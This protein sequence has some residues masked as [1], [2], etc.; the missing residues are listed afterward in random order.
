M[1]IGFDAKRLFCNFTGLGN[2]S[3]T[4]VKNLAVA[5]PH[6]SYHLYSPRLQKNPKTASFFNSP[7]YSPF[8]PQHKLKSLWRSYGIVKQ[9][10]KD[11]IDLYH[12]LSHE[13]PIGIQ[14]SK[15]KSIVTIHD[16]IFKAYP[17]TYSFFDR[18]I[19]DWK[20]KYSCQNA[21]RI[22]AIS[23]HT[24][25]DIIQHYHIAP[26]K[27]QVIYQACQDL[28]YTLNDAQS[29][30]ALLKKYALPKQY[31]LSVG[32]L[33]ER[34]NIKLLIKAY[35]YLPKEIQIPIVIVGNG[36]SYK[37]ELQALI[38]QLQLENLVIW[39]KNLDSDKTL[40]AL[41]QNASLFV[42]PSFYEGFGLPVAEAL[43]SK[44]PVITGNNSA[45]REA[46]GPNT[47]FI[48]PT[49]EQALAQAIQLVLENTSLAKKMIEKGYEYAHKTFHPQKLNEE[50]MTCYQ[51]ILT[52]L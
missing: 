28:Y 9:L 8:S 14:E 3:R 21:D 52:N 12:G 48:S 22:I 36:G 38:V 15:I 29:V 37:K 5:Y 30:A 39:I 27:I 43:L 7:P 24:K 41:Y 13:L 18:K 10:Q 31:I 34:K 19:Y 51:K 20:F 35:P 44:T 32:T 6:H 16:L 25:Q 33:Q 1:N 4:L 11:G 50:M 47:R 26:E 40:Q 17:N 2:Y 42:Y 23:E 45:L 46:G 49:N